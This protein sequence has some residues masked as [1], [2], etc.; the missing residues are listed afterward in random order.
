MP[1]VF[2]TAFISTA[3]SKL[4]ALLTELKDVDMLTGYDPT[5]LYLYESHSEAVLRLNAVSIEFDSIDTK[6]AGAP[7]TTGNAFALNTKMGFSV[8]VH[9]DYDNGE[10]DVTKNVNLLHSIMNKLHNNID[11]Q[12]FYRITTVTEI[13]PNRSFS[14]SRTFGGE[15]SV[16]VEFTNRQ[17]QE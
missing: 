8:R 16:V 11:L 7:V 14:E 1:A 15:L 4:V 5:F 9:T 13:N 10:N 12:D 6:R 2:G 17:T 3:K